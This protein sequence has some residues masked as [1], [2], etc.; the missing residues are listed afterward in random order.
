MIAS[1]RQEFLCCDYSRQAGEQLFATATR[2]DVWLL[3][4][5][6]RPWGGQALDESEL[7]Q[8]IKDR[9]NA[10]LGSLPNGRFQFIRRLQPKGGIA[11][12]V[13]VSHELHPQLYKFELSTYDDL[14]GLDISGG[15]LPV[16]HATDERLI[17]VCT[18]AKRDRSCG[19]YGAEV[20]RI[21][22][23]VGGDAV[24]QTTHIGGHRFA[25]TCVCLPE[26][27]A[28]GRIDPGDTQQIVEAQRQGYIRLENYRGR[29]C[30][31][32]VVQAAD[33]FLREHTGVCSLPGFRLLST[34]ATA[35]N[36]TTVRFE[37][38]ADGR[39]HRVDVLKDISGVQTYQNSTDAQPTVVPQ[40]RLVAVEP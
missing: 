22:L 34:E 33:Y 16:E 25:A 23:N 18:N 30:Y 13:A 12:Y 7:P 37:A 31:D 39:V 15:Q 29:S 32:A 24:W 17:A 8:A 36:T 20:F 27:V 14:L 4:E 38:L 19:R 28:Y 21:M 11:F 5:Y 35:E 6:N 2:V 26:G 9:L 1:N 3:L 10:M 40:F